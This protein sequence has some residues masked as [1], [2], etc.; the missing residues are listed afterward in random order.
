VELKRYT[1]YKKDGMDIT[2]NSVQSI[3]IAEHFYDI[4]AKERLYVHEKMMV[5]VYI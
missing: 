4:R 1:V 5:M 3:F 2:K